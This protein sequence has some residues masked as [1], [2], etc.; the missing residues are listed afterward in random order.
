MPIDSVFATLR[1]LQGSQWVPG[2]PSRRSGALV[3]DPG[4]VQVLTLRREDP[5]RV[6]VGGFTR[7]RLLPLRPVSVAPGP[8]RGVLG[9]LSVRE[10]YPKTTLPGPYL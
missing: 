6:G 9:L 2:R 10:W 4:R 3:W 8:G 1:Q 5:S 7:G